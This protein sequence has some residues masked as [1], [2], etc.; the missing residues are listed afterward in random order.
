MFQRTQR[1]LKL[2]GSAGL[3]YRGHGIEIKWICR[4]ML[5]G[6]QRAVKWDLQDNVTGDTKGIEIN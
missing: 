6:T 2:S 4:I 1:E 3:C 5:Q